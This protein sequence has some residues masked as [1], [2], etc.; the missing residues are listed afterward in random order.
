VHLYLLSIHSLAHSGPPKFIAGVPLTPPKLHLLPRR[1]SPIAKVT[2]LYSMSCLKQHMILSQATAIGMPKLHPLTPDNPSEISPKSIPTMPT[3]RRL[4]TA[5]RLSM[6]STLQNVSPQTSLPVT[7]QLAH[8]SPVH[9]QS[10]LVVRTPPQQVKDNPSQMA[11]TRMP[12]SLSGL[13]LGQPQTQVN[14][15]KGKHSQSRSRKFITG[16]KVKA[17]KKKTKPPPD[18]K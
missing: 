11:D 15:S 10:P 16:T 7:Q 12:T 3:L 13:G 18:A 9:T 17:K 8:P 5:P 4:S 1:T 14:R 6:P 2:V